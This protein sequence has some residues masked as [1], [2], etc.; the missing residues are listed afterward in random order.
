MQTQA[1]QMKNTGT[2]RQQFAKIS[3]VLI[4]LGLSIGA[5]QAHT[6]NIHPLAKET[7][8]Q[9]STIVDNLSGGLTAVDVDRTALQAIYDQAVLDLPNEADPLQ[10][11][12]LEDTIDLLRPYVEPNGHLEKAL[13][14]SRNKIVGI[15]SA[16][17]TFNGG[18]ASD[19]DV[20]LS[21]TAIERI[22][23]VNQA[24]FQ[25]TPELDDARRAYL[26]APSQNTLQAY[27]LALKHQIQ[28]FQPLDVIDQETILG[29]MNNHTWD[30]TAIID[31]DRNIKAEVKTR[32]DEDTKLQN[33]INAE[34]KTRAD[35]DT[36]LQDNIDAEAQTRAKADT[37]LG[38]R[39]TTEELA[40]AAADVMLDNKIGAETTRATAAE[41]ALGARLDGHQ[42]R[43]VAAEANIERLNRGIA[44]TAALVT[45]TIESGNN[46]AVSF[47]AAGYEG[48]TGFSLGYARR[49]KGGLS[50]NLGVASS[51][52]FEEVVVRGGV[53]FSW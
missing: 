36:K 6:A 28:S 38:G 26:S 43:L 37:A 19:P 13:T 7:K 52:Q 8:T 12:Y 40:R 1:K 22:A 39:I 53:N 35:E 14:D 24:G 20:E 48:D 34:A 17:D 23:A 3:P 42:T 2:Y 5:A 45:P 9:L 31:L 50:A 15:K 33:N 4:A 27:A 30:R 10:K 21:M 51:D 16:V 44:M 29:L 11:H 18:I 25:L 49:I 47:T 46:N 41:A 32:A